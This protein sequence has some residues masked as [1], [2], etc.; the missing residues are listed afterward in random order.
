MGNEDG[1]I[2]V[3]IVAIANASARHMG[4]NIVAKKLKNTFVAGHGAV[5]SQSKRLKQTIRCNPRKTMGY[6]ATFMI[7]TLG[8]DMV[9]RTTFG[10]INLKHRI[11]PRSSRTRFKQGN[12]CTGLN[13]HHTVQHYIR[14]LVGVQINQTDRLGGFSGCTDHNAVGGKRRI[15]RRQ[16]TRDRHLPACFQCAIK[17]GRPMNIRSC[18]INQTVNFNACAGQIIRRICIKNTVNK[19]D[20]NTVDTRKKRAIVAME[21]SRRNRISLRQANRVGVFPILITLVR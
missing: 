6:S 14:C 18:D 12:F 9:E 4:H 10:H 11:K 20:F 1:V 21:H 13:T 3:E 15:Q 17:I 8:T 7:T 5:C 16:R 2:M 19:H